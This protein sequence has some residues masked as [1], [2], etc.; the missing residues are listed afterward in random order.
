L[1]GAE[2]AAGGGSIAGGAAADGAASR[3][4]NAPAAGEIPVDR[5]AKLV[6]AALVLACLAAFVVTQRLKHT[7]TAVQ[8]FKLTPIFAP[9][10]TG[11]IKAERIS[12]KLAN[13]EHVTVAILDSDERVVA[14]LVND[15]PVMRYK[16]FSLRWNG[17]EG[18]PRGKTV[19]AGADGTTIVTPVNTGSQAPAGEYHVRVTLHAQNRSV[20]SPTGFT[21]VRP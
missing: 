15:W 7:P 11:H 20:L 8:S 3:A 18:A 21:L 4:G 19:V 14:T 13:A 16:Q 17:R 6:F 10:P 12:F 2:D 5:L 1:T 9:V